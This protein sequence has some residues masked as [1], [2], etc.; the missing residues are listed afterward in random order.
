MS[1]HR[2]EHNQIKQRSQRGRAQH[3]ADFHLLSQ[4]GQEQQQRPAVDHLSR[5][6][7]NW[8]HFRKKLSDPLRVK[9]TRRI[10]HFAEQ[11]DQ[12][13][14]DPPLPG[15]YCYTRQHQQSDP[16]QSDQDPDHGQ[17]APFLLQQHRLQ[18]EDDQRPRR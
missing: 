14:D 11:H 9:R 15:R 7:R 1:N 16:G 3:I 13:A 5:I 4:S 17:R 8:R 10:E 18:N 12:A 2:T 6:K